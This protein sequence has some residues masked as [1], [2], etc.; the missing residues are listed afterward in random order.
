LI[1]EI[2]KLFSG[3]LGSDQFKLYDSSSNN[4]VLKIF[5]VSCGRYGNPLVTVHNDV[6]VEQAAREIVEHDVWRLPVEETGQIVGSVSATNILRD[7]SQK[8]I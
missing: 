3:N 4:P 5:S 1:F 7:S 6:S 2:F 8:I